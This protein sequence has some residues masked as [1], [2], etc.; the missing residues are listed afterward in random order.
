VLRSYGAEGLR[1]LIRSH[2]ALAQDLATR[3]TARPEL[4]LVAPVPFSLVCFRH[5]DGDQATDRIVDA[6]NATGS[7]YVTPSVINAQR[8]IRVSIGQAHTEAAHIERLWK[9][10]ESVL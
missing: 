7:S 6:V 9:A 10:I 1:A 3:I 2:I 8:F 5:V 4:E